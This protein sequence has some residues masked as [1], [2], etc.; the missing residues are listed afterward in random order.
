MKVLV[1]GGTGFLGANLVR[2]LLARGEHVRVLARPI[3]SSKQA[4]GHATLHGLDVERVPGDL[5][6]PGSLAAACE[7]VTRVYHA[8]GYYPPYTVPV[9]T[10]VRQALQ[11]TRHVLEAVRAAKVERMVFVSALTTIGHPAQAGRLATEDCP[12]STRYH[13]N[14]YLMAKAEMEREVRQAAGSGLP[15]VIVC[16]TACY[17]PYDSKPTSGTVILMIARR[18]MPGYIDG[19]V[20]AIDAR[21]VAEGMVLAAERGRVGERYLLGNW[22]TTQ[23]ELNR[24]IAKEL[25]VLAPLFPIPPWLARPVFKTFDWGVRTILRRPA[26]VPGF[27]VEMLAHMQQYDCSKATRELGFTAKRPIDQAIRDAIVW[28]RANGYLPA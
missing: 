4:K 14:P 24:L 19:P 18:L 13:D 16:P 23:Q 17:G 2:A 5:N 21:D 1:L 11:E 8:A 6:E 28:F 22:N 15:A 7:G 25:G 26:P 20:N 9:D 27:F 3:Q 10:A 12:F